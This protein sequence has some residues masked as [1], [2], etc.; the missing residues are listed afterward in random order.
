MLNETPM[1]EN[2]WGMEV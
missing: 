2:V 1:Q